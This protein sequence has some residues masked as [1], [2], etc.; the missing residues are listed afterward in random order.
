MERDYTCAVAAASLL[1]AGRL[2]ALETNAT[3]R[4][5]KERVVQRK[6]ALLR[7]AFPEQAASVAD[8]TDAGKLLEC[9]WQED[10][11]RTFI[12]DLAF[13]NPFAPY[14]LR[15]KDAHLAMALVE[16]AALI[17]LSQDDVKSVRRTQRQALKAHRHIEWKKV[18]A[19]G[20]AATV[21]AGTGGWILAPVI[22]TAIGTAAGLSGAAATA[23]GLAILGGGSLAIGGA[24]MAG[25]MWIVAGAGA[26]AGLLGGAGSTALVQL[27]AATVRVEL[28]K[29]Q[30]NYKENLLRKQMELRRSQEV[31][32]ELARQRDE[33]RGLLDE[34]RQLNDSNSA[35]LNELEAKLAA[36]EDALT[37]MKKVAS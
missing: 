16:I 13:A 30:V 7:E 1:V 23:H 28:M 20:V 12:I 25:G 8:C 35:R 10:E 11:A 18:A 32:Q 24:G 22:G 31:M 17:G 15:F 33:M 36:F 14:E 19:Y 6:L 4:A 2:A 5:K 21:I 37:W 3:R 34:E 29:L 27:G 9:P 26:A